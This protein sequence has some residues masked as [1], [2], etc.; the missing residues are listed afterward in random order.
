MDEY[1]FQHEQSPELQEQAAAAVNR[2]LWLEH[3]KFAPYKLYFVIWAYIPQ[4][5]GPL[6][7]YACAHW[8]AGT[9]Y[10]S[11][12]P[13]RISDIPIILLLFSG[14]AIW[15]VVLV[16]LFSKTQRLNQV[17]SIVEIPKKIQW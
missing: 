1:Q 15:I 16:H 12:E 14:F 5:I 7:D 4:A 2:T 3:W 13:F 8:L 9:H 6:I 10:A 11:S 17:K